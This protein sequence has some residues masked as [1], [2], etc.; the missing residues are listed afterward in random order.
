MPHTLRERC[1]SRG[2]KRRP[3]ASPFD[4][5]SFHTLNEERSIA[6][7]GVANLPDRT[8]YLW[9]KSRAREAILMRTADVDIPVA[10]RTGSGKY[11]HCVAIPRSACA[12]QG[13]SMT[14]RQNNEIENGG[15]KRPVI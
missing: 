4:E 10:E 11:S 2:R 5:P 13:R 12:S 9:L 7:Q 15:P 6:L 14:V 1:R 3:Q 8:G